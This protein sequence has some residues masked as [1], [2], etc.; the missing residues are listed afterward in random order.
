MIRSLGIYAFVIIHS[1]LFSLW[2][3]LLSFFDKSGSKTHFLCAVPWAKVILW[4]SGIR[5]KVTWRGGIDAGVPRIYM[6]NHQSIFDIFAI[7]AYLPVG[8]KF[9]LKQELMKIPLLGPAMRR[10]GY[11][12]IERKEPRKAVQSIKVAAERIRNG[13]SVLIFPEGTRSLDGR[14]GEFKRGGFNL[15]LKSG[16]DIVPVAIS[17]SYRILPKDRLRINRTPLSICF[18]RPIPV[19]GY[20]KKTMPDLMDRVR[21]AMIEQMEEDQ[22]VKNGGP[23]S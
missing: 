12:G 6:S 10:A 16:C 21:R 13:A 3:I 7:L 1:I 20:T 2:G 19:R 5:A 11:I 23:T 14:L 15:A 8:F 18:G 4:V 9:V 22:R 17:N